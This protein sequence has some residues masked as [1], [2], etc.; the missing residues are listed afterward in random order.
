[1]GQRSSGVDFVQT[2]TYDRVHRHA[3]ARLC[4][5]AFLVRVCARR[6]CYRESSSTALRQQLAVVCLGACPRG[7]PTRRSDFRTACLLTP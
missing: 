4:T 5:V 3:A 6:Y 7:Y 1:M 2:V